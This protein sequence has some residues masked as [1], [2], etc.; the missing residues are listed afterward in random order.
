MFSIVQQ[1]RYNS[2]GENYYCDTI[3]AINLTTLESRC[4]WGELIETFKVLKGYKRFD[5]DYFFEVAHNSDK[6]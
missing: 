5:R 6:L 2:L 3:R 4:K 1:K